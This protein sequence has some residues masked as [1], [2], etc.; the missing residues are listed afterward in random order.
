MQTVAKNI[1]LS[2]VLGLMLFTSVNLGAQSTFGIRGGLNASNISFDKLSERGERIGYHVGVFADVPVVP[3]FF[4][5]QPE[6]SYSVKGTAYDVLNERQSLNMDYID[7][8]LPVAFKLSTI[9]LQVGP[10]ASYLISKP[11]FTVFDENRVVVDAF[12]AFDAGLTAG[13]SFNFNKVLLGIR[14]NQGFI[15]VSKDNAEALLGKGKNAVG[16]VSLGYRF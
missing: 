14:Y 10:F 7:F 2:L 6:L 9:D 13:L 15:N 11:D 12:N 5:L 1:M 3:N 8:H 16:Q 4:S